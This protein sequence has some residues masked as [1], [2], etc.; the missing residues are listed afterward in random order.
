MEV[1]QGPSCEN[2]ENNNHLQLRILPPVIWYLLIWWSTYSYTF[3]IMSQD[4]GPSVTDNSSVVGGSGL[5][6][7]FHIFVRFLKFYY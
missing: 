5:S 7:H 3:L 1:V 6:L 4:V 2:T